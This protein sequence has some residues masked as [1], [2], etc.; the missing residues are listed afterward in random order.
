M[1][2]TMYRMRCAILHLRCA[3]HEEK[4]PVCTDEYAPD[5]ASIT[6][7]MDIDMAWSHIIEG[8]SL[9]GWRIC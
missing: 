4:T 1:P 5:E 8:S 7:G 6:A 2:V 3:D 9:Y